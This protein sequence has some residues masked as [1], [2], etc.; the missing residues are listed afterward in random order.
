MSQ[1]PASLPRCI[2]RTS[3]QAARCAVATFSKN[4]MVVIETAVETTIA[5]EVRSVQAGG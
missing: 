3:I 4:E 1:N 2:R 5:T